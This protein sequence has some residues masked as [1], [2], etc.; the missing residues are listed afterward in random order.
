[1]LQL[2]V[3]FRFIKL[4]IQFHY[5]YMW[6]YDVCERKEV[7]FL[8]WF[9]SKLTWFLYPVF[10]W[11]DM[12]LHFLTVGVSLFP[13]TSVLLFA[14]YGC[15]RMVMFLIIRPELNC[16]RQH[17]GTT[18]KRAK[19]FWRCWTI[20]WTRYGPLPPSSGFLCAVMSTLIPPPME[21]TLT[22]LSEGLL[23]SSFWS[24]TLLQ[25]S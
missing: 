20:A 17:L 7:L 11:S 12:N 23:I 8:H 4:L 21:R 19:Y 16:A 15:L 22:Q 5:M 3:S 1:M 10:G 25:N 2:K 9:V 13:L 18:Q 6:S 14:D 24:L